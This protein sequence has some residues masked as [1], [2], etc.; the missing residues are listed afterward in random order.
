MA[1]FDFAVQDGAFVV[2]EGAFTGDLVI[3]DFSQPIGGTEN[4]DGTAGPWRGSDSLIGTSSDAFRGDSCGFRDNST[5]IRKWS[6]PG[7]GLQQYPELGGS[8]PGSTIAMAV[9]PESNYAGLS[10]CHSP[11]HETDG[12]GCYHLLLDLD[13]Y[14]DTFEVRKA[15]S[16]GDTPAL[17]ESSPGVPDNDWYIIAVILDGDGYGRHVCQLWGVDIDEPGSGERAEQLDE[18]VVDDSQYRGEGVGLVQAGRAYLDE[19]MLGLP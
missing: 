2:Q 4:Y 3:E 18:L 12:Y 14:Y 8:S 11:G 13:E 16:G 19:L 7:D 9:R 6:Y 5:I 17:A 10:F 15:N 1:G